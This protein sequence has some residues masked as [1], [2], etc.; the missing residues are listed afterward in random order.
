VPSE[1]RRS[2]PDRREWLIAATQSPR[3]KDVA[4]PALIEAIAASNLWQSAGACV[5]VAQN[6]LSKDV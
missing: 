3:H 1:R 5:A 6:I 4:S 2:Q